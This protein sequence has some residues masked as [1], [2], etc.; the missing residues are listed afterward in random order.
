MDLSNIV[1]YDNLDLVS[2]PYEN[3]TWSQLS[4]LE[5]IVNKLLSNANIFAIVT[6]MQL[7]DLIKKTKASMLLSYNMPNNI[8]KSNALHLDWNIWSK[9]SWRL[10]NNIYYE[11][12]KWEVKPTFV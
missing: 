12:Q 2:T 1:G 4:R 11:K 10:V 5:D 9:E 6:L 8:S 3:L 7:L